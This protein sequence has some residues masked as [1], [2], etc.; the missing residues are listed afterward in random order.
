M[1]VSIDLSPDEERRLQERASQLGQ[2]VAGYLRRLI[3]ENLDST[4][5][6]TEGQ[7]FAKLLAP[8]HQDF[9]ESGMTEEELDTLLGEAL[10]ESRAERGQGKNK[11]L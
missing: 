3:R 9:R 6:A 4:R 2:D 11:I 1:T 10:A 8:V 7:T 5:P